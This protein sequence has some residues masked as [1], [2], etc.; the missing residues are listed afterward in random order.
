MDDRWAE[1][2][3]I[4]DTITLDRLDGVP[5]T[6]GANIKKLKRKKA[7]IHSQNESVKIHSTLNTF[8]LD[9]DKFEFTDSDNADDCSN[10]NNDDRLNDLTEST[11]ATSGSNTDTNTQS[12]VEARSYST[13]N[14]INRSNKGTTMLIE[15]VG[16][17]MN[18]NKSKRRNSKSFKRNKLRS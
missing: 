18:T 13:Y 11:R 12:I 2:K 6:S 1:N 10:N 9:L 8:V 16:D 5:S 7:V 4:K 15:D 14:D 3:K 17:E